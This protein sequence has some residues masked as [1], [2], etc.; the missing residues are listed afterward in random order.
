M[1][2][3]PQYNSRQVKTDA[4]VTPYYKTQASA[5][6]FGAG[7]AKAL[8]GLGEK[9]G[10][11]SSAVGKIL[12][13]NA[14]A[15]KEAA[16]AK[17]KDD[18]AKDYAAKQTTAVDYVNQFNQDIQPKLDSYFGQR[19]KGAVGGYDA[20]AAQLTLAKEDLLSQAPGPGVADV[21]SPALDGELNASLSQLQR[22][23]DQQQGVYEDDVSAMRIGLS[24]EKANRAYN[25]DR[26]V[27][28]NFHIAASEQAHQLQRRGAS[29]EEQATA[30]ANLASS[31]LR[32]RIESALGNNDLPAAQ[33][34]YAAAGS[35]LSAA[36]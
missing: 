30:Q 6:A 21:L 22:H 2:S 33:R 36:D 20:V 26:A 4:A 29:P 27:A 28:T 15:E 3:I 25:D 5:E 24:Q 35:G 13:A 32:G 17:A 11:A 23:R 18:I 31:F 14:K 19:G 10:D 12:I 1:P 7:T 34:Y 16:D 8:Q 9:L